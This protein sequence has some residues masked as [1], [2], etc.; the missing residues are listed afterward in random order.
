EVRPNGD[1]TRSA[2]ERFVSAADLDTSSRLYEVYEPKGPLEHPGYTAFTIGGA[3]YEGIRTSGSGAFSMLSFAE[4]DPA[5]SFAGALR[6]GRSQREIVRLRARGFG[7]SQ[8]ALVRWRGTLTRQSTKDEPF[9][10]LI[11][12]RRVMVPSL[13]LKADL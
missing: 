8:P 11:N 5:R 12:G 3:L 1:T 6:C 4:D 10:L 2:H 9:P 13:H 7:G